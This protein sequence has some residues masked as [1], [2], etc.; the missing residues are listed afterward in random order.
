MSL[1]SGAAGDPRRLGVLG[2]LV[3]DRIW[4][5]STGGAGADP[6]EEWGGIAYSLAAAAAARPAG[7][8]I[9]PLV[10]L[11]SDLQR[12][13]L[14]FLR[15][16]PGVA[17]GPAVR[18]VPEP[19][20]RVELR[21]VDD[22]HRHERQLGGIGPWR[23]AELEPLLSGLDAL[24]VN[25]ISGRELSLE[26]AE[27]LR[28]TFPGPVYA[29]LHSI[30]LGPAGDGPREPRS[31]PDWPRWLRCFDAVQ[32]NEPELALLAGDED[33]WAFARRSAAPAARRV[34][35][36]LGAGGA[37]CVSDGP[38][39]DPLGWPA[40]RAAPLPGAPARRTGSDADAPLARPER[41]PAPRPLS[42]GDH[43]GAPE[44]AAAEIVRV[45]LP[46]RAAAGDPTGC[47][48]V[49][50]STLFCRLLAGEGAVEA[51]L[52]AHRAAAYNVA[53]RGASTL[54]SHLA[55]RGTG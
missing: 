10:R 21:Y 8:E 35:V 52:S 12:E 11:G 34:F 43:T 9:V 26:D 40:M 49:W 7:W 32:M 55:G 54:F 22:A 53:H 41:G 17:V 1:P 23:R 39:D 31:L 3:W 6:V 20:N 27:W 38:A 46:V 2:T 24:Y 5:P 28:S 14:V 42:A 51:I 50:G 47:G 4:H 18:V 15:S 44:P 48:D 37:A 33:P 45:P 16:L 13:G 25:F 19:N 29:D 36:T 30:F